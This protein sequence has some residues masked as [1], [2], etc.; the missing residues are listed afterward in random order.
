MRRRILLALMLLIAAVAQTTFLRRGGILSA[1]PDLLLCV[2]VSAAFLYGRKSGALTGFFAGLALDL[3][4]GGILGYY[5][6]LHMAAG[7]ICGRFAKIYFEENVLVPMIC[8]LT[9]DGIIGIVI[10][11]TRFFL[12]G[13]VHFFGYLIRV[14][15]PE[16]VW[17]AVFMIII[18][19]VI[20]A[21]HKL[22]DRMERRGRRRSWLKG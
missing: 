2:T 18:Y 16:A 17:T 6:L 22:I 21:G 4:Y 10:Y 14:I 20:L 13:R 5:A 15:L 8:V 11:I 1:T 7:Y 19:R 3:F 9:S 12:R